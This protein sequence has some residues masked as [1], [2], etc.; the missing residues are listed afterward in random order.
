MPELPRV[1]WEALRMRMSGG[2]DGTEPGEGVPPAL[3]VDVEPPPSEGGG[4]PPLDV[5][6]APATPPAALE[7]PVLLDPEP[8]AAPH[9]PRARACRAASRAAGKS[10]AYCSMSG[11]IWLLACLS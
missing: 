11:G 4:G 10:G 6:A 8:L 2:E 1:A 3:E 7:A 9:A 5:P